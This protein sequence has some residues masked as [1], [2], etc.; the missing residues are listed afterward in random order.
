MYQEL[1]VL[2][3]PHFLNSISEWCQSFLQS[4]LAVFFSSSLKFEATDTT[5]YYSSN[6]KNIGE[7]AF[8]V[9]L[10]ASK[11]FDSSQHYALKRMILQSHELER[12]AMAEIDAFQTFRHRHI[13]NLID[14]TKTTEKGHNVVYLLFPYM[15][16]GSLR[17]HLNLTIKDKRSRKPLN[18]ILKDF[19]DIC[20]ALN[21]L[22]SHH[23]SYVHQDIKPEVNL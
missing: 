21:V 15:D 22:H 5:V 2:G 7:G 3:E 18:S 8:S 11:A 13:L 20:E 19:A 1:E 12:I 16:R 9:V 23:P 4:L 17:D 6:N 14:H 10:K